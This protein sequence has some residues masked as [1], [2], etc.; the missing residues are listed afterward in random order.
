MGIGQKIRWEAGDRPRQNRSQLQFKKGLLPE[1][2]QEF[3]PV[4][5][6]HHF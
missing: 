5:E 6:S 2:P 3:H 4:Y 1:F